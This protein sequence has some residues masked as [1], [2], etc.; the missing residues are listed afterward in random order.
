MYLYALLAVVIARVVVDV[1][2]MQWAAL[3]R[4]GPLD[5]LASLGE[6]GLVTAQA[7]AMLAVYCVACVAI[8]LL[9]SIVAAFCDNPDL[10][11]RAARQPASWA[12]RG[13][14]DLIWAGT[15][16]YAWAALV[17][18]TS[19][20]ILVHYRITRAYNLPDPHFGELIALSILAGVS[21][22]QTLHPFDWGATFAPAISR[23][24]QRIG[25]ASIGGVVGAMDQRAVPSTFTAGPI[26]QGQLPDNVGAADPGAEPIAQRPGHKEGA[27]C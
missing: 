16:P 18:P 1:S 25:R 20:L 8:G 21:A 14:D 13:R 3:L 2:G 9:L 15:R 26:E 11:E 5:W 4:F 22:A 19:A 24:P 7:L 23:M 17:L 10:V 12:S 6:G 27:A